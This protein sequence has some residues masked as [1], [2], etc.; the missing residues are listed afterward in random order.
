MFKL[1]SWTCQFYEPIVTCFQVNDHFILFYFIKFRFNLLINNL[2]SKK[3]T[4]DE[5]C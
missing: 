5:T 4:N 3:P 2:K 1:Y